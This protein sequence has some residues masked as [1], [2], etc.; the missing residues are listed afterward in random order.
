M[1][2]GFC[3]ALFFRKNLHFKNDYIY[4]KYDPDYRRWQLIE[5][6]KWRA[7]IIVI[8]M[9]NDMQTAALIHRSLI[10]QM[11]HETPLS[12][13]GQTEFQLE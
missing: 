7:V 9:H 10:V 4:A 11:G 12:P 1:G 13:L 3:T 5:T 6:G 2:I 8:I